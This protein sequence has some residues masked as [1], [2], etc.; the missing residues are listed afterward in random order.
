M[1]VTNIQQ[2]FQYIPS[3]KPS[4]DDKSWQNLSIPE[5]DKQKI[6]Q[7]IHLLFQIEILI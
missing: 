7:I 3:L 1:G 4:M 5:K 2:T 6:S